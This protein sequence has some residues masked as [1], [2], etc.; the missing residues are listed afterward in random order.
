MELDGNT[1]RRAWVLKDALNYTRY[2]F[3]ESNG[4]KFVVGNHHRLICDKL[5][6]VLQ[7]KCSRLIIN[8]A[9]R[10]SKT[11]IA[12]K[13]FISMGLAINP[14]AKFIHLSYS[15]NLAKDN[16]IAIKNILNSEAYQELF[17]ARIAYGSD[18]K[19]QWN[20]E[21]GGGLYATS[22]L[23]QITGFGAGAVDRVDEDGN[24]LPYEFSGAIVIDDPI[25]P[26][27]ALSDVMRDNVNRRFET[28]IRSR[29][30]S[31]NTPIIIIM[32]RLHEKDLC[33]YLMDKEPGVWDVL[34]LPAITYDEEGNPSP[35]WEF[36]HTISELYDIK[37]ANGFVFET[38]YMQ[39]PKPIAGLMY[40]NSWKT[41]G[42]IPATQTKIRKNYTDTAD[43]GSDYCCSIDY[44]E[45]EIGNFI[46]DVLYTQKPMEYTEPMVGVMLERDGID[47]ANIEA[48]NGG[49]GFARNV[50]KET[51]S[52]G[53]TRTRIETFHQTANKLVRIYSHANEVQNLTYFPEDWEERWPE[54]H[55]HLVSFRKDGKADHDDAEDSITGTVE[56][57]GRDLEGIQF[58]NE[59][60]CESDR[61]VLFIIPSIDGMFT[62][63]ETATSND[64][65]K[66]TGILYTDS[67]SQDTMEEWMSRNDDAE[68]VMECE[69]NFLHSIKALRETYQIRL[70]K[71]NPNPAVRILAMEEFV[72]AHVRY[73]PG[74]TQ[75]IGY[76][77][78]IDAL[79]DQNKKGN[80][81]AMDAVASMAAYM[82]KKYFS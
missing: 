9:P 19:A 77:A 56:M 2:F 4:T 6:Q 26:E 61:R 16:S 17:Q 72:K 31:R 10:Y 68:I 14:G 80:I 55:D 21:Q 79:Q 33:G 11:E 36:K 25:K 32:Q 1:I 82:Q 27:D 24:P 81:G 30:N 73:N 42:V 53:N 51:R 60:P 49:Q 58:Y 8:I 43:T 28:T 12:V 44:V 15:G 70:V 63:M 3:K 66:V 40:P 75:D 34:S 20:T 38:Q 52:I 64:E 59:E 46:L 37:N 45:T 57:R 22:T 69:K 74:Y 54:F 13:N 5:N 35:L 48:N 29:V 47:I 62:I 39:D 78:F 18:T 23:G 67:Y 76:T 50:E 7:G 65:I 41:Y 71:R